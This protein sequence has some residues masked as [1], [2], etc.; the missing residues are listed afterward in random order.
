MT[1]DLD[2][3][4]QVRLRRR[5]NL[6]ISLQTRG[7]Q[8]AFVVKDPVTLRYFHL[9]EAQRFLVGMMDGNHT[10]EEIRQAFEKQHRPRRMSLGELEGFARQLIESGLVLNES[11]AAAPVALEQARKQ[12]RRWWLSAANIFAIK[13]PLASPDA[14]LDRCL[15]FARLAFGGWTLLSS[16]I[17]FAAALALLATHWQEFLARLPSYHEFFNVRSILLLWV[18]LGLVKVLHELGHALCCKRM[19]ASVQEVGVMVLFFFPTLYCNVSDSWTLASKWKRIAVSAAGIYV[20]LVIASL[21]TFLWWY[22]AADSF[23]HYLCFAL[24]TVCSVNTILC[25]ANPL[26]RFDGYYVLSDFLEI[27]NLAQQASQ[28]VQLTLLRWLGAEARLAEHPRATLLFWFGISSACYRWYVTALASYVLFEFMKEHHLEAL[29]G[30]LIVAALVLLV[31]LPGYRLLGWLRQ[32]GRFGQIKAAR[33]WLAAGA[34]ALL[35]LA[36]FLVPLP[37]KVRGVALVQIMP[38]Q[39]QRVIVPDSEGFLR[40][41][42][43]RDGQR[44]QP[45]EIIAILA[46]PKLDI[47]LQLNEADQ[48]L[49][50]QQRNAFLAHI[51]EIGLSKSDPASDWQQCEHELKSL[52]E[53]HRTLQEQRDRLILRAPAAGVI[54]GLPAPEE[55]GKWLQKGSEICRIGADDALRALVLVDSADHADVRAAAPTAIRIHGC[56]GRQYSGFVTGIAQVE[57]KNIPAPLSSRVAGDVPTHYDATSNADR[58]HGQHYLVSVRFHAIDRAIH[59]GVLGRVKIDTGS[60]TAW[61][62]LRQYLASTLNAGL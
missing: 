49:R 40:D 55:K 43:V 31:G 53:Q 42:R 58:P 16:L 37:H 14:W 26:L 45:G 3:R 34:A 1:S 44:V 13:L 9:D 7:D 4:K 23:L 21:A 51:A 57:A 52:L 39:T 47:K 2:G 18:S 19:G 30:M 5:H 12:N 17:L 36:F 54:M 10:L 27:P 41:I 25:N 50:H 48:A 61:Q 28:T 38:E 11:P 60:R 29:G 15:P 8:P 59:P 20:E 32:I 22:T 56:A 35:V 62:M 46:N 6:D 24:M 33:G